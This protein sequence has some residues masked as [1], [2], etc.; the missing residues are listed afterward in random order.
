M[1]NPPSH[2]SQSRYDSDS[3]HLSTGRLPEIRGE[4]FL[5]K[6]RQLLDHALHQMSYEHGSSHGSPSRSGYY[7][8]PSPQ[9]G[10]PDLQSVVKV[11]IFGATLSLLYLRGAPMISRL[12]HQ[13]ESAKTEQGEGFEGP[14]GKLVVKNS[15]EKTEDGAPLYR[16]EYILGSK[17]TPLSGLLI[18]GAPNTESADRLEPGTGACNPPGLYQ[19]TEI[20]PNDKDYREGEVITYHPE[21]SVGTERGNFGLGFGTGSRGGLT[22]TKKEDAEFIIKEMKEQRLKFIEVK[23]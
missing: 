6:G 20:G 12:V 11:V 16:G 17:V 7:G 4:G 19:V 15:G 21:E 3:S 18:C 22:H 8:A 13:P 9:G 10:G 2:F 5:E 14:V 1:F 23:D